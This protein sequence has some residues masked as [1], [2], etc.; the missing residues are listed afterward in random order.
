MTEKRRR[1]LLL[2]AQRT[3]LPASTMSNLVCFANLS[4]LKREVCECTRP[5][6]ER[7]KKGE[8]VIKCSFSANGQGF[9]AS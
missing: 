9:L 4:E 7:R 5:Q 2:L 8:K 1:T 3:P 6:A